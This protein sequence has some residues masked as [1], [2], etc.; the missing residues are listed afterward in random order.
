MGLTS[1]SFTDTGLVNGTTYYYKVAAINAG[2]QSPLSSEA[3]AT[4]KSASLFSA[5]V[6]FSSSKTEIPAGYFN[7]NGLIFGSHVNGLSYGWN[8]DNTAGAHDRNDKTSPDELHDS[9][10]HMQA[11][12]D[13]NASWKIAVPNGVYRIHLVTGDPDFTDSYYKINVNGVLAINGKPDAHHHWFED[14]IT[15]TVTDG[16]IVV[17]NA[18][19]AVNNKI[20][21]IDIV[22]VSGLNPLSSKTTNLDFSKGFAGATGLSTNGIAHILGSSLELTDGKN[23]EASSVFTSG[24]VNLAKFSTQFSF[25]I[26]NPQADGF[27]FTLQNVGPAALGQSGGGLGYAGIDHSV[28]IKFD[29]YNNQGEGNDSTGLYLNG[30]APANKG[31]IN[32][33]HTAINLHSGHVFKVAMNY[34][35]A[36]LH[37]TITDAVTGKSAT[38][39]YKVDIVKT[40]GSAQGYVGF[41]AGT[42]G[43]TA[44]EKILSWKYHGVS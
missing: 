9:L 16:F 38:Q 23:G 35:G 8:K 36:T 40:L 39:S 1:T 2:G 34:D 19:G 22:Q 21:G 12:S 20:D 42:G 43:K 37:V 41:T 27:T 30:A 13:P 32:L 25:Q 4:P 44:T 7:D 33:N 28:A 18:K 14:A 24:A 29:L 3:S 10:I 26:T 11:S 31:S 15:I 17:S 5:D 6:N